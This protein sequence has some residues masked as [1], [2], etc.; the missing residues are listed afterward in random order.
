MA[1]AHA[2]KRVQ[3]E[4]T[5]Y[6]NLIRNLRGSRTLNYLSPW[7]VMHPEADIRREWEK[8]HPFGCLA[9]THIDKSQRYDS[10]DKG[11][12]CIF[13]GVAKDPD[14]RWESP[15][16]LV[17]RIRDRRPFVR[18]DVHFDETVFPWRDGLTARRAGA[19]Q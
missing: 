10:D 2:P 8:L 11:E 17:E 4:A 18:R 1:A 7:E 19:T 16:Y 9:Y 14:G 6:A 5:N 15:G 3:V 12:R 13:L